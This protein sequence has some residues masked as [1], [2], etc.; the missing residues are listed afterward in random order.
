MLSGGDAAPHRNR[1]HTGAGER[2]DDM[3]ATIQQGKLVLPAEVLSQTNFTEGRDVEI[4]IASADRLDIVTSS[5]A[6]ASRA[7]VRAK[8]QSRDNVEEFL[9]KKGFGP[10]KDDPNVWLRAM[11]R[12]TSTATHLGTVYEERIDLEA[13]M[14]DAD[15]LS[16][17]VRRYS[18]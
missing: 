6:S 12:Q 18:K 15:A 14:A 1:H 9:K 2:G 5:S 7:I 13:L 8:V 11:Q 16:R 17:F 10:S 3:K 4:T